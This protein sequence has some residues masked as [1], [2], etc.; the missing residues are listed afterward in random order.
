MTNP[1]A[2]S[3]FSGAGARQVLIGILEVGAGPVGGVG[4]ECCS[5]GHAALPLLFLPYLD[6]CRRCASPCGEGLRA[7]HLG[8]GAGYRKAILSRCSFVET[9]LGAGVQ[10][11]RLDRHGG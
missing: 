4:V 8:C 7:A 3:L 5:I 2:P 1:P 9:G 10:F 11:V 6:S